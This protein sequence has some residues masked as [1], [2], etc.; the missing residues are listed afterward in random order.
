MK[1]KAPGHRDGNEMRDVLR[2]QNVNRLWC[3]GW[4]CSSCMHEPEIKTKLSEYS[5]A[6]EVD[7]NHKIA[8]VLRDVRDTCLFGFYE[9]KRTLE[10]IPKYV[11]DNADKFRYLMPK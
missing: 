11:V 10:G 7:D 3:A 8:A 1:E 5:H 2:D 9:R 4:H 6:A